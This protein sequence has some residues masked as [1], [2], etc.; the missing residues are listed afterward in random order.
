M[1]NAIF[2]N[3]LLK[4]LL[5]SIE[6]LYS[7]AQAGNKLCVFLQVHG[8]CKV[9]LRRICSI[10]LLYIASYYKKQSSILSRE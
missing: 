5:N 6:S 7:D 3:N 9:V 1:Q 10:P 2:D 8:I 4:S